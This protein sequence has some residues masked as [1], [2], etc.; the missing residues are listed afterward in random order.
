MKVVVD[1]GGVERMEHRSAA[2]G[3]VGRRGGT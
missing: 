1:D 2:S 3:A